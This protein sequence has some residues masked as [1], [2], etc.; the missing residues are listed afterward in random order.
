MPA[1]AL[2][3]ARVP[4]QW[5]RVGSRWRRRRR[6]QPRELRLWLTL[7]RLQFLLLPRLVSRRPR[8][9]RLSQLLLLLAMS[10]G[11]APIPLGLSV[12][13]A[14]RARAEAVSLLLLLLLRPTSQLGRLW[15]LLILLSSSASMPVLAVLPAGGEAHGVPTPGGMSP[16]AGPVPADV[17]PPNGLAELSLPAVSWGQALTLTPHLGPSLNL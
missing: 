11:T 4:E 12:A 7:A 13:R 17:V 9:V 1:W 14:S 16:V 15:L 2:L 6:G 3:P 8:L 5:W 10:P